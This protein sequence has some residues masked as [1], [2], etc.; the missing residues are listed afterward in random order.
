ME[1]GL[2][3]P[4]PEVMKSIAKA[5]N[6]S[7]TAIYAQFGL[8]D[9]DDDETITIGVEEAIRRDPRLREEHKHALLTMY[10]GLVEDRA[11]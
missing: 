8:L 1:R 11:E 9:D 7:P 4:S 10:R 3:R 2:Y 5:F 6:I